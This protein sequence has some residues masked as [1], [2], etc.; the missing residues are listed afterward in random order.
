MHLLFTQMFKNEFIFLFV[1]L[2]ILLETSRH[3][4]LTNHVGYLGTVAGEDKRAI[5]KAIILNFSLVCKWFV[6]TVTNNC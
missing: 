2:R 6:S 4:V 3:V 1:V 5:H